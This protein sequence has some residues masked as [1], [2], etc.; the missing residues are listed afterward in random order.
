M[1]TEER[2]ALRVALQIHQRLKLKE[3]QVPE[4]R[5]DELWRA[6]KSCQAWA[7]KWSMAKRRGWHLAATDIQRNLAYALDDC[8]V[9]LTMMSELFR[10]PEPPTP[11]IKDVQQEYLA[12][13]F[14]FDD[15]TW[16]RRNQRLSVTTQPIVLE[17]VPLG[18][19]EIRL[20]LR[21]LGDYTPY[22]VIAL[23]PNPAAS[24]S[25]VTHPHVYDQQLCE[26]EAKHAIKRTLQESRFTDFFQLVSQTLQTYNESSPH[27]RL[28][29]WGGESCEECGQYCSDDWRCP[30]CDR[31][32]CDSCTA[33]CI[34]CLL[35]KCFD[36]MHACSLCDRM[37]CSDCLQ[38]CAKCRRRCCPECF[39]TTMCEKCHEQNH[40]ANS[41]EN[42]TEVAATGPNAT[43]RDM[44]GAGA[45]I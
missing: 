7:N 37:V 27:V 40:I 33:N 21:Q 36:C 26:G 12:L 9:R 32:I 34:K 31:T 13:R 25:R 1:T 22:R 43:G 18:R 6:M 5:L 41:R 2:L 14:D 19:F 3:L 8:A 29:Q 39:V 44:L 17:R 30:S 35:S 20:D 16:D 24:N 42:D 4:P 23:D 10:R 11:T 38:S 45:P 28:S 15:V